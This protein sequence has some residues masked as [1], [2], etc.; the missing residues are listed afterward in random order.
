M[1]DYRKLD[2]GELTTADDPQRGV[3]YPASSACGYWTDDWSRLARS[4]HGIPCCPHCGCVGMQITA[5]EWLAVPQEF[6]LKYPDY[7]KW[8]LEIKETCLRGTDK[9]FMAAYEAWRTV[10]CLES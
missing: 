8:L 2:T 6:L 9:T 10:Q 1:S 5:V 7:D 4:R 3:W